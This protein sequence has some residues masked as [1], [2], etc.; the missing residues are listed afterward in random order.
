MYSRF[1]RVSAHVQKNTERENLELLDKALAISPDKPCDVSTVVG[2]PCF[3]VFARRAE[4]IRE[5]KLP[6]RELPVRWGM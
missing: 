6:K 2:I 4:T 3:K 5:S 1:L